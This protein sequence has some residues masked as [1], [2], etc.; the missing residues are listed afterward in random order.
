MTT[1]SIQTNS[2]SQNHSSQLLEDILNSK[3]NDVEITV[4]D[5][6][7]IFS[8][9]IVYILIIYILYFCNI[10]S[11]YCLMRKLSADAQVISKLSK[12]EN[13]YK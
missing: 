7:C 12:G 3:L 1:S 11:S 8:I 4:M 13:L 6:Y 10:F 5:I 9:Y 2:T